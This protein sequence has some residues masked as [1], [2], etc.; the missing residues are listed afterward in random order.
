MEKAVILFALRAKT[1]LT[2]DR[3]LYSQLTAEQ[4]PV[5]S[6]IYEKKDE[7]NSNL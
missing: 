2:P 5:K 6:Y 3:K 4:L 7:S 1:A